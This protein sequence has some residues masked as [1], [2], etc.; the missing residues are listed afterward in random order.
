MPLPLKSPVGYNGV[1]ANHADAAVLRQH[2][3]LREPGKRQYDII[4]GE[5]TTVILW[6]VPVIYDAFSWDGLPKRIGAGW[7]VWRPLSSLLLLS[8]LWHAWGILQER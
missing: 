2:V 3:R 8:A 7:P 4:Y 1:I 5:G 6:Q